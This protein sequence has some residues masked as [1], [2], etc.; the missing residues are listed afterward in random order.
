MTPN[1]VS[2]GSRRSTPSRSDSGQS[3][4]GFLASTAVAAAAVAGGAPLLTAC[5]G[6]GTD[7]GKKDGTTTGKDAAKI[8]PAFVGSTVVA[9]DLAPENG[10]AAGFTRA[11]PSAGLKASVAAKR[12]KGGALTIMAPFWG[13]PPAPDNPYYTAM[14]EAIGVRATWQNQDGNV[15]D[16]K[17]GAVLAS[18]EIP[19]VVVVPGWNLG[20]KIPSA[21]EAKFED[22]GP[23]LSGDKVKAYP[24][25]AA[26]PTDAWQRSI[27][28]GRLRGLPM[29]ASYV[30]NIAPFYRKDLF[31]A[32]GWQPPTSADEFLALA[33][34]ITSARTKVWACGDLTWT[35]YNMFGVLS[36][37]D[38]ALGW[39]LVDGKLVN[40][41]ETP[42]YLEA[43]AWTRK[44]F[45][46][47][48]VHPD[49]K[50]QNQG[51]TGNR[52]TA[53]QCLIYNNDLSHWYAKTSEQAAQ[54]PG[55]AMAAMDIPGHAGGR[56]KLWAT[57]P[58]NIWA[59]IRKGS[60]KAVVEDVLAVADF[61]AAP[62]GTKE[63][64]LTDYGVEGVHHTVE[65]GLPVKTDKGNQE[66]SSSWMFVASPAPYI[67]HPDTPE[68][69]RAMIEWQRR[70]G[71]VTS[72]S[73]FY[74]MT[75][76]EPS[77]WT[78]LMNDFEQLE[79]DIVRGRKKVSD[80]Q[81]AVSEWKTKG[82]DQLRDWYRKLLD[83]NGPA[84][85]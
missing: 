6:G 46:A 81:Q 76:T 44:L 4:R 17:L 59:F 74:G 84:A 47:G 49:E 45:D 13:P 43:L 35:A 18:S 16:Q 63:R 21:V 57:N 73:S 9:P 15:Y 77:R 56:P 40:R 10:S 22:L 29:P 68:V 82:G 20:G 41:I 64:M 1:A 39:T 5:G 78:G 67:A 26:I 62:Y 19:D 80:M 48:V 50:A 7:G 24:N 36:G 83:T 58:A 52:F 75:V 11:I 54:N 33:K 2:T 71:A 32:K 60:S 12:G 30:T 14:N 55:F 53:G 42:E 31:D 65:N 72:K 34:E 61:T 79:K 70:M 3:R 25:L 51:D 85:G 37:S 23:Y 66:V 28:G 27:F 38:K 8:L 69:T